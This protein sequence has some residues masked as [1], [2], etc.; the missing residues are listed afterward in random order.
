[1]AMGRTYF[2]SRADVVSAEF[3]VAA[4][5]AVVGAGNPVVVA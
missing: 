5:I 1:M 2:Q 3:V 4:R